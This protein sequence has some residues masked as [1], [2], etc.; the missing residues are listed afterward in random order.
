MKLKHTTKE[1]P[2]TDKATRQL[3]AKQK[4]VVEA[5]KGYAT[6]VN[7]TDPEVLGD[8]SYQ[9]DKFNAEIVQV[10]KTFNH[11]LNDAWPKIMDAMNR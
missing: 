4:E 11:E 10:L 2:R 7:G 1:Q 3:I 8:L 5:L 6:F 9:I